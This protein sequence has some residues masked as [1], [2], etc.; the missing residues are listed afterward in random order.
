[1]GFEARKSGDCDWHIALF[2]TPTLFLRGDEHSSA[3]LRVLEGRRY[4]FPPRLKS[5]KK[6]VQF[7]CVLWI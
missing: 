1:M 4:T 5:R 7:R 2:S 3:C 6:L